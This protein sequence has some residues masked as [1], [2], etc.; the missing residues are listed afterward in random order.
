M[1]EVQQ[2]AVEKDPEFVVAI[3]HR[4]ACELEEAKLACSPENKGACVMYSG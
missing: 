2:R 4:K 1:N 3:L